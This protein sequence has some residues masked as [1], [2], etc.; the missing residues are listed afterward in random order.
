MSCAVSSS[1]HLP[2]LYPGKDLLLVWPLD[3]EGTGELKMS[4]ESLQHGE[5]AGW[6]CNL[7]AEQARILDL[8]NKV[9][10]WDFT[11]CNGGN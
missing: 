9:G 11:E 4:F 1:C 3:Q 6:V 8:G 2:A 7:E 10:N 5:G